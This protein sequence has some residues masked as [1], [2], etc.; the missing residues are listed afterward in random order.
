MRNI[1]N[2]FFNPKRLI[3]IQFVI[4]TTCVNCNA[5]IDGSVFATLER[6]TED[7]VYFTIHNKLNDSI[8][9]F[10]SYRSF[11]YTFFNNK[12]SMSEYLHKYN[13][14]TKKFTLSL[15]PIQHRLCLG[16]TDLVVC[17]ADGVERGYARYVFRHI[18][19]QS[20]FTISLPMNS[21]L[22]PTYIEDVNLDDEKFYRNKNIIKTFRKITRYL[23]DDQRW[24]TIE[25]AYFYNDLLV[26][27]CMDTKEGEIL[28]QEMLDSYRTFSI[29][30]LIGN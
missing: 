9:F 2:S 26:N 18:P 8:Y 7:S 29:S 23:C 1:I 10:D 24:L 4:I 3:L 11:D 16:R 14:E 13:P 25:F 30:L 15:T 27:F 21:I 28:T 20:N 19:P 22:M 6:V 12:Y 5:K 17:G